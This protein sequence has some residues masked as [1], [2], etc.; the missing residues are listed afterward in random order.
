M[1]NYKLVI[2]GSDW[3]VYQAA[4]DELIHNPKILYIETFRPSGLLGLLQRIQF[5]P[6]LNRFVNIPFKSCWNRY[7]VRHVKNEKVCFLILENWLRMEC[8][9]KLLP[10]LR[11][12]FPHS[13]IICFTQDLIATIKDHYSR[14]RIDVDYIKRYTDLFISYDMSDAEKYCI[15]YH[16]TV[17]S[18]INM[19][20]L[21]SNVTP[22][23]DLYF[24]GRDKGRLALL[25]NLCRKATERGLRCRFLLVDV[26]QEKQIVCDGIEY[27]KGFVPYQDNLRN[28]VASSCIVELLQTDAQS[29][30][31]RVWEAIVLKRK[32]L[33]NNATIVH[34]DVY[35]ERY[36]SVFT[37]EDDFDW[38][39]VTAD[40]LP[41]NSDNPQMNKIRPD[42]LLCFIED[43]L[44]IQINR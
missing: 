14:C 39:F 13:K 31:F 44:N 4:Y 16:P 28:C 15:F 37:N 33:T 24:L 8:G 38:N 22:K 43:K 5:N 9:I 34:S 7:Y 11:K 35:D 36:I 17:F 2:F 21:K 19:E 12:H 32:L 18:P 3:D 27:V 1:D 6:R 26:P 25:V 40:L 42:S 10:Y 20:L 29:P 41:E 30:T 23:C